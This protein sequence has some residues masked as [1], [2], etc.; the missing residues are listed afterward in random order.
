MADY[1]FNTQL[2]PQTAQT[3]LGDMVNMAR[4]IQAY[5]QAQQMNPLALQQQQLQL[6][7]LQQLTPQEVTRAQAEAKR[8]TTEADVSS[9]TAEPRISQAKTVAA[10]SALD[11]DT[12]Q[13]GVVLNTLG[14]IRNDPRMTSNPYEVL[15]EAKKRALAMLASDPQAE[16]KVERHFAPLMTA[17]EEHSKKLPNII[18]SI[19]QQNAGPTSQLGLMQPGEGPVVRGQPTVRNKLTG[20]LTTVPI[21]GQTAAQPPAPQTGVSPAQMSRDVMSQPTPIRFPPPSVPHAETPEET[22]ERT[23]GTNY[24]TG[25]INSATNFSSTKRTLQDVLQSASGLQAQDWWK[26]TA[27]GSY[28]MRKLDQIKGDPTYL[29]LSKNLA[30]AQI[31]ALKA[32]GGSMD[33]VAGQQ[34]QAAANG[35]YTYPPKALIDITQRNFAD[36]KDLEL[37]AQAIQKF[38]ALHGE[39]NTKSFQSDW[40]KNS[41]NKIFQ[42]MAINEQ[43]Q[44]PVQ[45]K[46]AIDELLGNNPEQRQLFFKKYNNI[47]KLVR[48]GT[49]K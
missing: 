19:I 12:D 30:R 35:D 31:E 49:L 14:A 9:Q 26:T 16:I 13:T 46:R 3:S 23:N 27:P 17:A 6:S 36:L 18:D 43:I 20:A 8:A 5:Q 40:A 11:F 39:A 42:A 41:D 24:A 15:L 28:V 10:K 4:G 34:L 25:L 29:E 21:D 47:Q 22:A 33:T 48:D 38:Q 1:G 37:Q 32:R 44:D 2:T 45:K 7:R